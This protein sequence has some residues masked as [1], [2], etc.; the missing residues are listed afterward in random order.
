VTR[1]EDRDVICVEYVLMEEE[2]VV[3]LELVVTRDEDKELIWVLR[4]EERVVILELV[5]TRD[6]DNEVIDW[7]KE[8][9]SPIEENEDIFEIVDEREDIFEDNVMIEEDKDDKST[10]L[11]LILPYDRFNMEFDN[12]AI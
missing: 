11:T 9:T 1:D 7:V 2:R 3:T 6:E 4:E 12:C 5:V 10:P 8:D